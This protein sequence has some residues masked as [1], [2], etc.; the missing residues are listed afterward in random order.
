MISGPRR[1]TGPQRLTTADPD[2]MQV[3]AADTVE[4]TMRIEKYGRGLGIALHE[5]LAGESR[6]ATSE[7][8]ESDGQTLELESLRFH[9]TST[10]ATLLGSDFRERMR[11]VEALMEYA[12]WVGQLR[13]I[14]LPTVDG[15][16]A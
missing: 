13:I 14:E 4:R 5:V 12:R 1:E 3:T 2:A 9:F 6:W 10:V 7:Y 8:R 11:G 15:K 16:I